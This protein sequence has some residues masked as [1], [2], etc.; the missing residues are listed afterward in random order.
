MLYPLGVNCMLHTTLCWSDVVVL[1]IPVKVHL[2]KSY[3]LPLITLCIGA[4][5][6]DSH[7]IS[8]FAVCWNDAFH[9]IFH[10]NRWES[11]KQLQCFC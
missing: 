9:K 3:S 5:E 8:D 11:V 1:L 6:F 2:I 4:L 10:F 7:A